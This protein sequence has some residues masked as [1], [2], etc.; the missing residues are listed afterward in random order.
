MTRGE[1]AAACVDKRGIQGDSRGGDD[2]PGQGR[3]VCDDTSRRCGI[4]LS[5][6]IDFLTRG[7]ASV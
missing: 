2:R 4:K 5:A 7:A 6:V 1:E 3:Q